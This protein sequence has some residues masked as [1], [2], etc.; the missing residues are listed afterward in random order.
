L[1]PKVRTCRMNQKKRQHYLA[2]LS[3]EEREKIEKEKRQAEAESRK[4][5]KKLNELLVST[6]NKNAHHEKAVKVL[7]EAI[8][9]ASNDPAMTPEVKELAGLFIY[10]IE[11]RNPFD[12][13]P[14]AFL[15]PVVDIGKKEGVSE[16]T[17]KAANA[18]HAKTGQAKEKIKE[19]WATGKFTTR[20]ICAEQEWQSS[21]FK[22]FDTARKALRNTPDPTLWP[23]K[24]K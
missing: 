11:D 14:D 13:S 4:I 20:A 16:S 9:S 8:V 12:Y 5:Q 19:I 17:R 22:S 10:L 18:K 15:K 24:H 1:N 3:S 23:A 21:G 7:K 2:S 6:F